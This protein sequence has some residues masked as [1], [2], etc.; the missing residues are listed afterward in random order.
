MK[1]A[2]LEAAD[3]TGLDARY[4]A[5]VLFKESDGCV[6]VKTSVSPNAGVR[7]PGLFQSANGEYTCNDPDA[8][9]PMQNPCPA[10]QIEGE[11]RIPFF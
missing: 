7:N 4:I 10:R 8:G 11:C 2:V 1:A 6:R 9:T 3:E 5:A